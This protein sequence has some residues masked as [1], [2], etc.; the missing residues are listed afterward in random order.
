MNRFFGK[1]AGNG[2]LLIKSIYSSRR[3]SYTFNDPVILFKSPLTTLRCWPLIK[4][5]WAVLVAV[6]KR[7]YIARP[8]FYR[9]IPRRE[10]FFF[11]KRCQK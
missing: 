9:V 6:E 8:I 11:L 5:N 7:Y 10:T 3:V 1:V 2:T 4:E